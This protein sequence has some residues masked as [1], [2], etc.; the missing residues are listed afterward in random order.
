MAC[1]EWAPPSDLS[2]WVVCVWRCQT[3][4][5]RVLP[6]GCAD[7]VWNGSAL[8]VVGPATRVSGVTVA[9]GLD[10]FG[11]RFR[12][13]AAREALG[14][15]VDELLDREVAIDDVWGARGA[16]L[17]RQVEAEASPEP[18]LAELGRRARLGLPPPDLLVRAAVLGGD[19]AIGERQLRRRFA[20]SVGLR[21]KAL[22]SVLRFQRF[23][24]LA[25]RSHEKGLARLAA[26]AGYADQA[27]L[28]R[29]SRRLAG[30]PPSVLL[31]VGAHAA[32]EAELLTRPA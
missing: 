23:L 26:N 14:L 6:D 21:P 22:G 2:P 16:A 24:A 31:R 5:G 13:G 32:G 18:V 9:P 12:I 15:P 17:M 27:H 4:G 10:A 29:E 11:V 25:G 7:I 1:V 8:S 3:T 20:A 30:A 19:P 28:A